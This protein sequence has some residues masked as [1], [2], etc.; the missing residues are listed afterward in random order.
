MRE[1][2]HLLV[3]GLV[4]MGFDATGK[5]LLTV[6]HS[7]RGVFSTGTWKRVARDHIPF[8]PSEGMVPGIGSI[9]GQFIDV[10]ERD[11][12]RD[13]MEAKSP[14]GLFVLLGRSDGITITTKPPHA[15]ESASKPERSPAPQARSR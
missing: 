1:P 8:Y 10:V 7:G 13:F 15:S 6:S 11:E 5:F 14:D 3:G 2:K 9:E 12:T 4:A